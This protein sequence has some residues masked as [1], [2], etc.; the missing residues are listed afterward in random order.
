MKK[1]L[2]NEE[3]PFRVIELGKDIKYYNIIESIV[4]QKNLQL[5]TEDDLLFFILKLCEENNEYELL[6]ENVLLEYC[7]T[8]AIKEFIEYIDKY[9]CKDNHFR[10]ILKCLDRR[11]IQ[12]QIPAQ[13]VH[14]KRYL[15]PKS[16]E[17]NENDQLNGLLRQEYL[18]GNVEMRTSSTSYGDVYNLLQNDTN[19]DFCTK[20]EQN[21][22]IECNLKNHKP[23]TI[24][25]YVIR[26]NNKFGH[27]LKSWKLEGRQMSDRCWIQIDSH[28]NDNFTNLAVKAF[29]I[30]CKEKFDAVRLTQTGK[31][32]S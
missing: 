4:K 14:D 26:G 20:D 12:E 31:K 30:Q 6:F 29:P 16:Y 9:I 32:H 24:T 13:V 19:L 23:F 7:S 11:L 18:K 5:E 1:I 25:K 27:H 10:C 3:N 8:E 28:N 21:S 22:W 2:K 17:Y 15:A